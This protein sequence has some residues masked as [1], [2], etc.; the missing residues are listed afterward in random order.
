M[1]GGGLG[2]GNT[3]NTGGLGSAFGLNTATQVRPQG[4]Q[5]IQ[6]G[7]AAGNPFGGANPAAPQFLNNQPQVQPQVQPAQIPANYQNYISELARINPFEVSQQARTMAQPTQPTST[8]LQK[9]GVPD[10]AQPYYQELLRGQQPQVQQA[11]QVPQ[12]AQP[13]YQEL[14]RRQQQPQPQVQPAPG[15]GLAGLLRGMGT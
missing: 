2:L 1:S 3:T 11:R 9:P 15:L 13:Y 12:F 14:L 4:Q 8:P 7:Q 6:I 5:P 10:F